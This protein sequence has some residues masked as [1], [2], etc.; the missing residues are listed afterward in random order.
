ML[1]VIDYYPFG[2]EMPGRKYNAG[3][4]RYG[5]NGKEDDRDWGMQNVQDYYI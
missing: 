3:D 2:W 4:Y 1:H 5:F